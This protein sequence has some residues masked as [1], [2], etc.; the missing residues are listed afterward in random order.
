MIEK[1]LWVVA[2]TIKEFLQ[3]SNHDATVLVVIPHIGD[4]HDFNRVL[5][6]MLEAPFTYKGIHIPETKLR[7]RRVGRLETAYNQRIYLSPVVAGVG[8]GM[9][10]NRFYY[11][12]DRWMDSRRQQEMQY[13]LEGLM[14]CI[15]TGGTGIRY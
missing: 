11:P 5:T 9:S 15:S 1:T 14:P 8:R 2:A 12:D 6:D 4:R 7:E 3:V 10:I 13:L